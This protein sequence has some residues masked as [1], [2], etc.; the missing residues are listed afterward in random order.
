LREAHEI[1][2]RVTTIYSKPNGAEPEQMQGEVP[3]RWFLMPSEAVLFLRKR[4]VASTPLVLVPLKLGGKSNESKAEIQID[5][6]IVEEPGKHFL[7]TY[8]YH[9]LVLSKKEARRLLFPQVPKREVITPTKKAVVD[10]DMIKGSTILRIFKLKV[11]KRE[12][13]SLLE[14]QEEK[15]L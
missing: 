15:T 4:E 7:V 2:T 3:L 12:I 14:F 10:Y 8:N 9:K 11:E 5:A 6:K 1:V 13:E